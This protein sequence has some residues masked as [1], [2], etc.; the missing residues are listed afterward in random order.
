I[1]EP[2][3]AAISYASSKKIS[4]NILVYDLGGGTFDVTV[5]NVSQQD[6][7]ILA[8]DGDHRL[9]GIDFDKALVKL[10]KEKFEQQ[11]LNMTMLT[12]KEEMQLRYQAEKLKTQLS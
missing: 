9:G 10:I 5:M 6:Y 2:T 3:A 4:G 12:P 8:T 1:N 7:H 11:G